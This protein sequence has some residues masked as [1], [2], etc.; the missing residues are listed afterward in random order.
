MTVAN[1]LCPKG[2]VVYVLDYRGHG[3]SEGVRGS[4]GKARENS[5]VKKDTKKISFHLPRSSSSPSKA[6]TTE[7]SAKTASS[8]CCRSS[9]W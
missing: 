8:G 6:S 5:I 7:P 4:F 3:F 1:Y 2:Y 9:R